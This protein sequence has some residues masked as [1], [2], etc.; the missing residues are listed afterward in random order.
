MVLSLRRFQHSM[1][2]S[3]GDIGGMTFVWWDPSF[4]SSDYKQSLKDSFLWRT[5]GDVEERRKRK[6]SSFNGRGRAVWWEA[7]HRRKKEEDLPHR[8]L[9]SWEWSPEQGLTGL[10][11]A[12]AL[13]HSHTRHCCKQDLLLHVGWD[14]GGEGEKLVCFHPIRKGKIPAEQGMGHSWRNSG[15]G[16]EGWS[17]QYLCQ[18]LNTTVL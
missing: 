4:P 3:V 11:P 6:S 8:G 17:W 2:E 9:K 16:W 13:A 12:R 18:S 10:H 15:I 1:G 5:T 14:V 7:S